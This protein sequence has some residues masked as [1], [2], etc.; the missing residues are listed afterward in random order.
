MIIRYIRI[1]C[2]RSCNVVAD[3]IAATVTAVRYG[4]CPGHKHRRMCG[5][6]NLLVSLLC[7]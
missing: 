4:S 6:N 3:H 1:N 5:T 7:V 2:H